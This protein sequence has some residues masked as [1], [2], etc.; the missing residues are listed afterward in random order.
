MLPSAGRSSC[1]TVSRWWCPSARVCVPVVAFRRPAAV[2]R[3]LTASSAAPPPPFAC[4]CRSAEGWGGRRGGEEEE[5]KGTGTRWGG[6]L[7]PEP[8]A[9]TREESTRTVLFNLSIQYKSVKLTTTNHFI[10]IFIL[11]INI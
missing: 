4:L 10:T 1:L 3:L 8:R 2:Q 5:G 9:H 6:A 7:N 11:Y